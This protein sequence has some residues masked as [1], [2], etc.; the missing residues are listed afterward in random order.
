MRRRVLAIMLAA[1]VLPPVAAGAVDKCKVKLD[2]KNGNLL[3]SAANVTGALRYGPSA[4]A[5]SQTFFNAAACV[6]GGKAKQCLVGDPATVAA[7]TPPPGCTL[8]FADDQPSTCSA[9]IKGC[10]PG[11]RALT[12]PA[13]CSRVVDGITIFDACP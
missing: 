7:R 8:Y 10:T 13:S 2:A 11:S 12:P 1:V 5:V 3:V 9:W 4:D 6:A